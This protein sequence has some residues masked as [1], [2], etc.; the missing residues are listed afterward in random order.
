MRAARRP[1]HHRLIAHSQVRRYGLVVR[2][3]YLWADSDER[4]ACTSIVHGELIEYLSGLR[5][6]STTHR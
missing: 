2:R 3:A 5:H 4:R 1:Q 6:G